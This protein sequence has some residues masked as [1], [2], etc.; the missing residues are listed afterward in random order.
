MNLYKLSEG[1]GLKT[2][3]SFPR[4]IYL[5]LPLLN[6]AYNSVKINALFFHF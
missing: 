3:N 4:Y 6:V 1:S 5:T 2:V